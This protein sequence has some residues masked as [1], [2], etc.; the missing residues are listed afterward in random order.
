MKPHL[1]A[2]VFVG[3]TWPALSFAQSPAPP[4]LRL[5]DAALWRST[6]IVHDMPAALAVWRDILGFTVAYTGGSTLQDERLRKLFGLAVDESAE[7]Y[8]LISGNTALGNIGFLKPSGAVAKPAPARVSSGDSALFIKTT[9]L[10]D[11][12]TKL[13]SAN[14]L[15]IAAPGPKKPGV[16]RM[17][18]FIDPNGIRFV[19]TE[20][21]KIET[22]YPNR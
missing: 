6:Y 11:V 22:A 9:K 21:D 15:L 18:W 14:C 7:L 20:R 16:N 5:G 12:T 1:V 4:E 17:A 13:I 19:L 3:L 10:D 8:V 2:A